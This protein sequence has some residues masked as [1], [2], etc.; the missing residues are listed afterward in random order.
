MM[1]QTEFDYKW[2][3]LSVKSNS[4]DTPL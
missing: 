1:V 3:M 2:S 4:D